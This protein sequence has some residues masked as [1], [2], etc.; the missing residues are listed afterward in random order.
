MV[1]VGVNGHIHGYVPAAKR[2]DHPLTQAIKRNVSTIQQK[3]LTV[4]FPQIARSGAKGN[5][6]SSSAKKERGFKR[7]TPGQIALYILMLRRS[8]IQHL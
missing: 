7:E 3:R 8:A 5:E 2:A 1:S 4:S 6:R